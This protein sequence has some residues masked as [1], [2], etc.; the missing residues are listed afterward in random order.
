MANV[1]SARVVLEPDEYHHL[2]EIASRRGVS[3]D[4][5]I[6][7]TVRERF[8]PVLRHRLDAADAICRLSI[9]I[10]DWEGIE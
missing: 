10:G 4:E 6:L 8:L 3:V 9:P 7:N 1:R 2:E 5:L